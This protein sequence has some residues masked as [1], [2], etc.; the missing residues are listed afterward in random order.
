VSNLKISQQEETGCHSIMRCKKKNRLVGMVTGSCAEISGFRIPSGRNLLSLPKGPVRPW[1]PPSV[2]LNGYNGF[3][4][5][6]YRNR[7]VRLTSHLHLV[8]GIRMSGAL[9]SNPAIFLHDMY[10]EN[11][12]FKSSGTS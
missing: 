3:L 6:E 10:C 5:R 1:D 2:L 9:P 12:S 4:Y 7:S 11:C 8:P